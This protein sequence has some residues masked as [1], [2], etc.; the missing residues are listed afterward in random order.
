MPESPDRPPLPPD[1]NPWRAA[2]L[3]SAIGV[4]LALTVG[5]GWWLGSKYDQQHGTSHGSLIGLLVGLTVGILT[6]AALIRKY[7]GAERK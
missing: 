3:V 7:T 5:L 2:G 6:I 4:D 1:D